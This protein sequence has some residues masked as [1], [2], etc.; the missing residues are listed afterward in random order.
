[1][2]WKM[3]ARARWPRKRS[4]RSQRCSAT[5]FRKKLKPLAESRWAHDPFA[6][7]SYSHALPG[8]ADKRA[9]LAAPVDGRLFF[10][11]EA[12]SP[13]F[14][15]TAHGARD[16]GKRAAAEVVRAE[17]PLAFGSSWQSNDFDEPSSWNDDG[18]KGYLVHSKPIQLDGQ[19]R[20]AG[21]FATLGG[22]LMS[23][24]SSAFVEDGDVEDGNHPGRDATSLGTEQSVVAPRTQKHSLTEWLGQSRAVNP[25]GTAVVLYRGEHGTLVEGEYPHSRLNSLSFTDD[26]DA[27]STYA[28]SPNNN[29]LDRTAE[30]PRV[31]PVH[32]R[33]ENPII[34][35]RND[36]FIDLSHL[37]D[38]LGRRE[39]KRIALKFDR[40]IQYTGNWDDNYAGEYDSVAQLL[41]EKPDE[42]KNLYFSAHKFLDDP[43][44]VERLKKAG[45][46]GAIHIGNGE[47]ASSLEYRVFDLRQVRSALS[48]R[49]MFPRSGRK[50]FAPGGGV[51]ETTI[52][53]RSANP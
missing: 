43:V 1:M 4:T 41:K 38:K 45:Y 27:A 53:R 3:P 21:L 12:T 44:E 22:D 24:D 29:Q 46:D 37:A 50:N 31:T 47:T 39:A 33:I 19:L 49:S 26:S 23:R 6:R 42:L 9:V 10:A 51:N 16:S 48:G 40:D 5:N 36:P 32:L 2:R 52:R 15:S 25:D 34:E 7:G 28:M 20:A 30:A 14:F 8:H 35:N 18:L 13:N 17:N 11:G